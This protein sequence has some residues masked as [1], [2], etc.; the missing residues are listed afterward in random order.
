MQGNPHD[1]ILRAKPPIAPCQEIFLM[2]SR[3]VIPLLSLLIFVLFIPDN[4]SG[5]EVYQPK[6][7][8]ASN[9]GTL[10][11]QGFKIP[12]GMEAKLV[13][14]EPYLANPVAFCID[15]QGRF[16]VCETFRQQKGVEDN[17]YHMDWLHD[18]LAAQTVKDRLA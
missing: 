17:R 4:V 13:A 9:E 1:R 3:N 14:A 11:I 10:A 16:Y 18:D 12:E 2:L 7:A 6:I 8:G 5:E 15:A